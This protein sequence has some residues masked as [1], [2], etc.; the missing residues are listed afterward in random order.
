MATGGVTRDSDIEYLV[1]KFWGV[2][3]ELYQTC[4]NKGYTNTVSQTFITG[5]QGEIPSTVRAN[6]NSVI[7][8]M[9]TAVANSSGGS[10]A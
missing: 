4:V 7:Q 8:A 2:A 5:A 1:W 10:W 3:A 6:V 9:V